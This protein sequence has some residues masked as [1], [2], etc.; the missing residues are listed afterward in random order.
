M[1]ASDSSVTKL[2]SMRKF[3]R[4]ELRQLLGK[5]ERSMSWLALDTR[6]SQEVMLTMPRVQPADSA[7]LDRWCHHAVQASRLQHPNLAH[8][9]ET[10]VQ[11]HWPYLIVDRALGRTLGEFIESRPPLQ[12][13]AVD[14]AVQ[15]LEGLAFVHQAGLAHGDIQ[16]H[17]IVVSEQGL[18]RV[19]AVGASGYMLRPSMPKTGAAAQDE[20]QAA[21]AAAQR[22]VMAVGVL[23]HQLLTGQPVLDEPDVARVIDRLPPAGHDMV[24]L[25]WST[26]QP[27]ADGLRA[28][29][30]RATERQERQRYH[31]VRTLLSA[32]VGWQEAATKDTG[33]PLSLLLD[34]LQSVGH[35]PTLPGV[36][37][38]VA[39]VAQADGQHSDE[40]AYQLLP[41]MALSF[42]LIRNVNSALV[43]GTQASG[44][45]PVLTLRRAIALVGVKGVRQAAA[46]LRIWPGPLSD[47]H[48]LAL[49]KVMDR[50]RLAGHIAQALGPAGYDLEVIY[51][52][53]VLQSLGRLMVQ[54]HFPDEAEQIAQLMCSLPPAHADLP[55][56]PGMTEEAA[57]FA[58]LGVDIETL[59][60]AVARHWGLGEEVL[61]MVRRLPLGRPVR[62]ADN[63][64]DVLRQIASAANEVVD[65]SN[66]MAPDKAA[67]A[68][69]AVC[70]RYARA[71]DLSMREITEALQR[72][73]AAVAE[74]AV[75]GAD[76]QEN[77]LGPSESPP[78]SHFAKVLASRNSH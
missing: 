23:L 63:D 19:M 69:N 26:P 28:I 27:I 46:S 6:S 43:Q 44:A 48:A 4:F 15:I 68:L 51:L 16:L 74:D 55:E 13:E 57:S 5:S 38:R 47:T 62:T 17:Q 66:S 72:A 1:P 25:P 14:W 20:L 7:Q 35:L 70:Q 52:V 37:T 53:T 8:V 77:P 49:L 39:R 75:R 65:I 78:P 76:R 30:N 21:R 58:V 64:G 40:M 29:V 71:L 22:D 31:N 11:D 10:G 61:H 18:V 41:D 24:R 42:E 12:A 33:G 73:H 32:L 34:R 45:A 50:C 36:G 67:A 3:G 59:G 60:A 9:V 56:Q 2:N 54:Y